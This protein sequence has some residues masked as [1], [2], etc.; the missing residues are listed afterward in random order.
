MDTNTSHICFST[1]HIQTLFFFFL[2]FNGDPR[3][4]NLPKFWQKCYN[5]LELPSFILKDHYYCRQF[6]LCESAP[7]MNRT[8]TCNESHLGSR[9]S[10]EL[11]PQTLSGHMLPRTHTVYYVLN[12]MPVIYRGVALV[13]CHASGIFLSR[14]ASSSR[15]RIWKKS[16]ESLACHEQDINLK[17]E[18]GAVCNMRAALMKCHGGNSWFVCVFCMVEKKL[19]NFGC[20]GL[21]RGCSMWLQDRELRIKK[22][23]AVKYDF[24]GCT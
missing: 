14:H 4:R 10:N 9:H 8:D 15:F 20:S 16:P 2:G 5:W 1:R 24:W 21:I 22:H 11:V 6:D 18:Q 17:S 12:G 3:D 7:E 23:T 19:C 13:W